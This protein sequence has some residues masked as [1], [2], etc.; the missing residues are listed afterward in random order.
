MSFFLIYSINRI[1]GCIV[2][3]SPL[4]LNRNFFVFS[5]WKHHWSCHKRGFRGNGNRDRVYFSGLFSSSVKLSFWLCWY[6]FYLSPE[7]VNARDKKRPWRNSW[8]PMDGC[9]YKTPFLNH[10]AKAHLLTEFTFLVRMH[11]YVVCGY[12]WPITLCH[13]LKYTSEKFM[14]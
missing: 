14:V 3:S 10:V 8:C 9:K 6:L 13:Y 11:V 12:W 5:R 7:A 1:T 4:I 2:A